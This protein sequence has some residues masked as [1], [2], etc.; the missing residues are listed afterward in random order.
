MLRP[1]EDRGG[2]HLLQAGARPNQDQRLP[3]RAGGARDPSLQGL[4]ADPPPRKTS[5]QWRGHA[6][7]RQGRRSHLPDLRHPPEHR[8]SSRRLLP[9]VRGRAE[10]EGD[11]GHFGQVRQ[12]PSRG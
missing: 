10:Q 2:R 8:Q 12:D 9:E 7:P 6:H 5:F 1:Q 11:Q 3:N 4:R